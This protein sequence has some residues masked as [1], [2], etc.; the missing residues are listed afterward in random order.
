MPSHV[1]P[2]IYVAANIGDRAVVA[3]CM[4]ALGL[5]QARA[6][7]YLVMFWG[8]AALN[9]TDGM[10]GHLTDV[11]IER[12]AGWD[13][14]RGRF[15]AWLRAE[16]LDDDGRPNDWSEYAGKLATSREKA[17]DKKR[18]QRGQH[19][20]NTGDCPGDKV[21]D[22]PG[23]VPG[24]LYARAYDREE[25]TEYREQRTTSATTT[26]VRETFYAEVPMP[27]LSGWMA[28]LTAWTEGMGTPGGKA[29]TWE[30][31]D[32]GLA[33]YLANEAA[34][35]FVPRHVVRYVEQAANRPAITPAQRNGRHGDTGFL[36]SV[37]ADAEAKR[38]PDQVTA[39]AVP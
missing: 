24:T 16:H 34:P 26:A 19:G 18:K 7:G 25:S 17:R 38:P 29:F 9:T 8:A 3:R 12:W 14:K 23:D 31:I 33:E 35:T 11:Q 6:V 37:I 32:A 15:A 30:Q 21:G 28:T 27:K 20:D 22:S 36:A 10:V 2:A 5:S 1:D 13:G 39:H 4:Q